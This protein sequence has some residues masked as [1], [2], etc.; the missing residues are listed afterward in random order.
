MLG[1]YG[2][3]PSVRRSVLHKAQLQLPR[4]QSSIGSQTTA[5]TPILTRLQSTR[6]PYQGVS[7]S[8]EGQE[9]VPSV[10]GPMS[11]S[12]D[13]LIDVTK[14]VVDSKPWDKDP[15]CSPLSWRDEMFKD[16]QTR[17]LTIAVMRDDGVVRLHPPVARVLDTVAQMLAQA[18][19][20]IVPWKPGTLHQECIDIMVCPRNFG[21][22]R[23][24]LTHAGSILHC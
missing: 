24:L 12:I 14:A 11:R 7:V 2:L 17:P 20:E 23:H 5:L 10:I 9:H 18:G 6:L 8:T 21:I 1:L 3:K 13:S 22:Y 19:H 16:I 15:K 4:V